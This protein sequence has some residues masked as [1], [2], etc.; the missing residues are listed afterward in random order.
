MYG[1]EWIT[2]I[3]MDG[4]CDLVTIEDEQNSQSLG[5]LSLVGFVGKVQERSQHR[6]RFY[7]PTACQPSM[8]PVEQ[9]G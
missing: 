6:H 7:L 1:P 4:F 9:L 2:I 5:P 3:D 8:D